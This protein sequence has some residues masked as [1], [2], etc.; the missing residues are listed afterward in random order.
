MVIKRIDPFSLGKIMGVIYGIFGLIIGAMFS[1]L[2][3]LGGLAGL[4]Q[5]GGAGAGFVSLILGVGSIIVLPLFYGVVGLIGGVITGFLFNLA[6]GWCGGLS[7]EV[8]GGPRSE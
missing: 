3:M 1:L 4:A 2:S 6:A 7:I 8:E 5:D